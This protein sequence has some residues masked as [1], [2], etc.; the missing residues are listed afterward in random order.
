MTI[1]SPYKFLDSY[2]EQDRDIFFG[3]DLEIEEVYKK[4]F[5]GQTLFIYGESGTGKSSLNQL[6]S[7][8]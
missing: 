3:R 4:V 6:R 7:C 5:Q 1:E 8:Q 2:T